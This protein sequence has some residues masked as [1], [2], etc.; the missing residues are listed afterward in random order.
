MS[1]AKDQIFDEMAEEDAKRTAECIRCG[2]KYD[3]KEPERAKGHCAYCSQV[4]H[5]KGDE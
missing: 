2:D 4:G 3:P 5:E 1:T